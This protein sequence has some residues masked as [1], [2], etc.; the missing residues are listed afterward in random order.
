MKR[1]VSFKRAAAKTLMWIAGILVCLLLLVQILLSPAVLTPVIDR[2]AEYWLDC[3]VSFDRVGINMFRTFPNI[4]LKVDD[5]LV[6]YDAQRYGSYTRDAE[7]GR[8]SRA[9]TYIGV[10]RSQEECDTVDLS[11]KSDTLA[12]MSALR[13]TVNPFALA[14]NKLRIKQIAISDLRGYAHRY[15]TSAMNWNIV[16]N[17]YSGS[18]EK[19]DTSGFTMPVPVIGRITLD[20]DPTVVFTDRINDASMLVTLK[21]LDFRGNRSSGKTL[22]QS[23]R[24]KLDSVLVANRHSGSMTALSVSRLRMHNAREYGVDGRVSASLLVTD[25]SHV[26]MRIPADISLSVDVPPDTVMRVDVMD[27]SGKICMLP[28]FLRGSA[29]FAKDSILMNVTFDIQEGALGEVLAAYGQSFSDIF[30]KIRTDA[31]L[32]LHAEADGYYVPATGELPDFSVK[33]AVP[34]ADIL[35]GDEHMADLSLSCSASGGG[36]KVKAVLDELSLSSPGGTG[37]KVNGYVDDV[38]GDDPSVNINASADADLKWWSDRIGSDTTFRFSGAL[39]ADVNGKMKSSQMNLRKFSMADIDADVHVHDVNFRMPS[40]SIEVFADSVAVSVGDMEN[41]EFDEI[42]RGARVMVS[43]ISVD[44]AF[45]SIGRRMQVS[46]S[47]LLC[48]GHG[49]GTLL[50]DAAGDSAVMLRPYHLQLSARRL[51]VM[52]SDSTRIA[53][54]NTDNVLKI[55]YQNGND[56]IPVIDI[57]SRTGMIGLRTR[58]ML[59]GLR[60]L[61]LDFKAV[62]GDAPTR[63]MKRPAMQRMRMDTVHNSSEGDLN[64]SLGE[65]FQTF[66]RQWSTRGSLSF[67]SSV[68]RSPRYPL[69]TSVTDMRLNYST[70]MLHLNNLKI[71]SGDTEL[72]MN[73]RVTGVKNAV[74]GKGGIRAELNIDSGRMDVNEILAAVAVGSGD[75]AQTVPGSEEAMASTLDSSD[76]VDL[77]RRAEKLSSPL[78]MLPGNLNAVCRFSGHSISVSDM[79]VD[80]LNT[81]V[82]MRNRCLRISD[83][84]AMTNMGSLSFE[85]F[86]STPSREHISVGMNLEL[87]GVTA[88]EVIGMVPGIDSIMPMLSSFNGKLKCQIAGTSHLDTNMRLILPSAMG[89][90]RIGGDSLHLDQTPT[91]KK[92]TRLLMFK[93]KNEF[94][95]KTMSVD[96]QLHD[97]Q[98]EVF[99]F[100]LNLDRYRVAASGR[101]GLDGSC[102]YHVSILKSPLPFKLG[103]DIQGEDYDHLKFRLVRPRFRDEEK[104]PAFSVTVDET[105]V[106]LSRMIS[107]IFNRGVDRMMSDEELL[108]AV[109]MRKQKISYKPAEEQQSETIPQNELDRMKAESGTGQ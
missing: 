45:L 40:D 82:E 37:L 15:D 52:D 99:P 27:F 30:G 70:N 10:H 60:S 108:K 89:V 84:T 103:L 32:S 81:V 42:A 6:K 92:I 31:H 19:K 24:L 28:F 54:R 74:L 83:I 100:I 59:A 14:F 17:M 106:M 90:L 8:A 25:T 48:N 47:N 87:K 78:L 62:K 36:K 29:A 26:R 88:A 105:R 72:S 61:N 66:Y 18:A 71:K 46:L 76:D 97:S 4:T 109:E 65:S 2:F 12:V 35:H 5:C 34:Q 69:R 13:V 7:C 68:I 95:I 85:G 101:M 43:S 58:G 33:V 67:K 53:L 21:S 79:I 20:G 98:L 64:F 80:S 86:Y 93:D 55:S 73:G 1:P 75:T 3:D 39:S 51:S 50:S 9:G 77:K 38:L 57:T 96:A 104:V 11:G 102:L 22:L 23:F 107:D 44:T 91:M 63:Y 49:D 16:R 94:N 56:T 41:R